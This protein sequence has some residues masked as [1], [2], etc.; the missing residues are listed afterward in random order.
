MACG[1]RKMY[2]GGGQAGGGGGVW[3]GWRAVV[4]PLQQL[5]VVAVA[6]AVI[7]LGGM[8]V[9]DGEKGEEREGVGPI[10]SQIQI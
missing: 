6:F 7:R 8:V 5:V 9:E 1:S 2:V 3:V 10:G 4:V